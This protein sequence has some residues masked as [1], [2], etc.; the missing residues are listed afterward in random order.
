MKR[1]TNFE[2]SIRFKISTLEAELSVSVWRSHQLDRLSFFEKIP[3][4][5]KAL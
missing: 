5:K 2:I 3:W 1:S 4:T